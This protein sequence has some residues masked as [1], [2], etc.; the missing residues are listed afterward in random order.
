MSQLNSQSMYKWEQFSGESLITDLSHERRTIQMVRQVIR[1]RG[2]QRHLVVVVD[3]S[4][5][6][7]M[8]DLQPSRIDVVAHSM[9]IFVPKYF[10]LNPLSQLQLIQMKDGVAHILTSLS[11]N[12]Q[13]HLQQLPKC[14]AV[15]GEASL[16]N[17]LS[18]ADSSLC[19]VPQFG[20]RE[21]LILFGSLSSCDPGNIITTVKTMKKHNIKCNIICLA[22]EVYVCK[23]I[24]QQTGG[25]F[26][27]IKNEKHFFDILETYLQPPEIDSQEEKKA[28]VS[29]LIHMGFPTKVDFS[30][31]PTT[32]IDR[33]DD[34]SIDKSIDILTAHQSSICSCHQKITNSGYVCP[35]CNSKVCDIPTH[36]NICGLT[37]VSSPDL[38]QSYRHL[39]PVPLYEVSYLDEKND[40]NDDVEALVILGDDGEVVGDKPTGEKS[41]FACNEPLIMSESKCPK[42]KHVFCENCDIFIHDVLC[43]CP[44]CE[45][46]G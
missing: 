34:G 42:C 36:C 25:K 17:A 32:F 20:T 39:F 7:L 9:T 6:M 37:L 21:V 45:L 5:A 26:H 30:S 44:G 16:Q 1:R 31:Q 14:Y 19:N 15:H 3:G 33:E 46:K 35:Q 8:R 18:L 29:R 2:L 11:G 38:A 24:T 28:A 43:V 41:C 40:G 23:K 4:S 27:V 22:A 13:Q 12:P 10:E